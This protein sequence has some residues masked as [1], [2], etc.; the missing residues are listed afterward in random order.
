MRFRSLRYSAV[1]VALLLMSASG[2]QN[3]WA[4]DAKTTL[5]S[6][7]DQVYCVCGGC[8]TTLRH[9][10][11][12]PSECSSRAQMEDQIQKSI[13]AGKSETAIIQDLV[14]RYG[15][16]V[17]AAPPARGFNLT[18]WVL[19][20]V[21]LVAGFLFLLLIARRWRRLSAPARAAAAQVDPKL[22]AAVEQEIDRI[23][24]EP[25]T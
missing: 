23:L 6:I 1:V 14:L 10:P 19:P 4:S 13:A 2:R 11:H 7:S 16:Q 5:E 18:V 21:G 20:G 24:H 17:R 3:A 25:R 22:V 12:L 8:V 15:V 9:C